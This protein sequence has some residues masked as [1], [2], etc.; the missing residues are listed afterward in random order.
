MDLIFLLSTINF[1][2]LIFALLDRITR[3]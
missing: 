2:K 3:R 1:L